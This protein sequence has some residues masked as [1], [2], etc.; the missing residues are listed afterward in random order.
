MELRSSRHSNE[1][2]E[3]QLTLNGMG[4]YEEGMELQEMRQILDALE[5]SVTERETNFLEHD[6]QQAIRESEMDFMPCQNGRVL[7]S[8]M[9]SIH[10]N[11]SPCNS[12]EIPS[13]TILVQ[14]EVHHAMNWSPPNERLPRKR[15]ASNNTAADNENIPPELEIVNELLEPD[16]KRFHD[17]P[18]IV[19][20]VRTQK[21]D[22]KVMAD[23]SIYS[24]VEEN[25]N[26]NNSLEVSTS[27]LHEIRGPVSVRRIHD[28]G[29]NMTN[30]IPH[31][32]F[33]ST[34]AFNAT[35]TNY[36][37]S[38]N[39]SGSF[40]SEVNN[41]HHDIRGPVSARR[42]HDSGVNI[43]GDV[44]HSSFIN[45]SNESSNYFE[46]S[47]QISGGSAAYPYELDDESEPSI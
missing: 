12:P 19:E 9:M 43:S 14:A 2:K 3:L 7:N 16:A 1:Y 18:K 41:S 23:K 39:N 26:S 33:N 34:A 36:S 25:N 22:S 10:P 30:D 4:F 24:I 31:S 15:F 40:V 6:M 37:I 27:S 20:N 45:N 13:E 29:F 47:A 8:T 38:L 11:I 21:E 42:I 46:N 17:M 28:S 5:M 32:S 44:P 35:N